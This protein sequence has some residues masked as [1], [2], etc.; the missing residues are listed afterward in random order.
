MGKKL[1][2]NQLLEIKDWQLDEYARYVSSYG[3]AS[4]YYKKVEIIKA[5]VRALNSNRFKFWTSEFWNAEARENEIVYKVGIT[6]NEPSYYYLVPPV[7]NFI[8]DMSSYL[9]LGLYLMIKQ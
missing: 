9:K 2:F 7:S 8:K 6:F 1:D 4:D 5:K 3:G